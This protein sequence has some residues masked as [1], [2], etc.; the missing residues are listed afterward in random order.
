MTNEI[1]IVLI[2]NVKKFITSKNACQIKID[3]HIKALDM[4]IEALSTNRPTGKWVKAVKHGVLSFAD[5]YAECDQCHKVTFNG[6]NMDYCP[7]CG[8]YMKGESK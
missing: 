2:K 3:D 6:W 5:V 4:A 1:A 7:N 8:A